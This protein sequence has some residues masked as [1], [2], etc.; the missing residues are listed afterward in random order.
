MLLLFY[1]LF[2]D[3]GVNNVPLLV[4]LDLSVAFSIV[5]HGILLSTYEG[6]G[7]GWGWEVRF[8]NASTL[9]LVVVSVRGSMC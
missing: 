3:L 6:W 9:S 5:D 8:Y 2:Q 1:D 4:L 7:W